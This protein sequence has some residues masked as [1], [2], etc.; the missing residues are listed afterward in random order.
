M[1]K[2][3]EEKFEKTEKKA[4]KKRKSEAKIPS[5][6]EKTGEN[7]SNKTVIKTHK[8]QFLANSGSLVEAKGK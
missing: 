6:N 3:L 7:G 5:G 2:R 8:W 1:A 4:Q